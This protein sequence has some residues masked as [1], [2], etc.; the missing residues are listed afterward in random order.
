MRATGGVLF[1]VGILVI[2]LVPGAVASGNSGVV[3]QSPIGFDRAS[4][5]SSEGGLAVAPDVGTGALTFT[6]DGSA[7][8]ITGQHHH[9]VL[10]CPIA[11]QPST[12]VVNN[13]QS[14]TTSLQFSGATLQAVDIGSG[15]LVAFTSEK[16]VSLTNSIAA[17]T[18]SLAAAAHETT[19]APRD[20]YFMQASDP[21]PDSAYLIPAKTP[22]ATVKDASFTV[23]GGMLHLF[24][25]GPQV[26]LKGVET[27][28][29]DGS[30]TYTTGSYAGSGDPAGV[31]SGQIVDYLDLQITGGDFRG[32][33]SAPVVAAGNLSLQS[34]EEA[35]LSNV[36]GKFDAAGTHFDPQGGAA[37][38]RGVV[39]IVPTAVNAPGRDGSTPDFVLQIESDSPVT[40]AAANAPA[41]TSTP[42][43]STKTA[44]TAAAVGGAVAGILLLAYFWPSVKWWATMLALPLYSRIGRQEVLQHGKRDEIYTL[45]RSEPGIHAH[46][47]STR[48]N[49]GWGTTVYHL[50]LLEDHQLVVAKRQGRYKRFFVAAGGSAAREAFAAL[51]NDTSAMIARYIHANAGTGQK[52]LCEALDLAP[53]LVSWH[54]DRLEEAQLVKK[55]KDGRRVR[56]FAGPAWAD[57]EAARAFQGSGAPPGAAET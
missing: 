47:I 33:T 10:T 45:I 29:A 35:R 26:T 4:L 13:G 27:G 51:R 22:F 24:L 42:S 31:T 52:E 14:S 12:C 18:G 54:I 55:V 11:S 37:T 15:D 56:Y 50:K 9:D 25:F 16:G 46:D 6:L 3:A 5:D 19:L 38:I 23:S 1:A 8:T 49:I 40:T 36:D 20:P 53:S 34:L 17:S 48:A 32:S 7:G 39:T 21:S 43:D 57:L 2:S 44:G 41:P 28:N 30:E